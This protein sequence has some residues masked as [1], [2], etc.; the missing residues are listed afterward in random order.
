MRLRISQ[1]HNEQM[2]RLTA[3]SFYD[4]IAFP[5]ETGCILLLG[6]NEHPLRTTLLVAD[7]LAPEEGDV[8]QTHNGLVFAS[9]YLR[10]ALLRVRA[11]K[12]AGFLT[13]HT[14]PMSDRHVSF[15]P[16]D[17]AM[18]PSLMANLYD[19]QPGGIFGSVVLGKRSIS[20]R[21]WHP[22]GQSEM[23]DKLVIV[24]E[25]LEL[26]QLDNS[27][28]MVQPVAAEIFDRSL[29]LT[30]HGALAQLAQ[31]RIGLVGAS[32]T[33]A[34]IGELLA[35]AGVGEIVI[36]E[37]DHIEIINLDRILHSRRR[38]VD[39]VTRKADRLAEAIKETGLPT[40]AT[41]ITG[42]DIRQEE[43]ANEL[44]GC[45]FIFGCLDN[46]HWPRLIL[47]QLAH[48]YL[49]P[50]IDLGTEIGINET[51][52]QSLDSRVS[53]VAPGRPCLSCSGIISEEQVRLEG[54][55]DPERDRVLTMGYSK[56]LPLAAPA[57]MDLNMRAA[58][59]A[60]LV[61]RHL[62]Q[63]FL[64]VPVPTHIKE[65]LTNYN[66]KRIYAQPQPGCPVCEMDRR[67]GRGDALR[68]NTIR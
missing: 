35:R 18:D 24:G 37:F 56:D 23:I 20:A 12:L 54:L 36:F 58:S 27:A 65:G 7:V 33:G 39:V 1:Q 67:L 3:A 5:P 51:E 53:Y 34:L 15:S 62:L 41:V 46:R 13:V 21:V 8:E 4:G 32:G 31:M 52:V 57:V 49:I 63:P 14:H 60:V 9:L 2:R 64:D 6:R 17:D 28:P 61:L 11:S 42:G 30:G 59:Y 43:V 45:D 25:R 26:I 66:I 16:Y 40:K 29:A 55:A 50:Y 19:L 47:C 68:M 38:D 48:Q 10:R 22:D 44:R